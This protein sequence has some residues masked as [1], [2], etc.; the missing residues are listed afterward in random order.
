ML[1]IPPVLPISTEELFQQLGD[2]GGL[3]QGSGADPSRAEPRQT[4]SQFG[5]A[6]KI[7][8]RWH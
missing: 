5:A 8:V 1:S 6:A 2:L 4:A 7:N 3:C